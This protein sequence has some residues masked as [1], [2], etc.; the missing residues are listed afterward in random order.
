MNVLPDLVQRVSAN[1]ELHE[2]PDVL[3]FTAALLECSRELL[4]ALIAEKSMRVDVDVTF[5]SFIRNL[6]DRAG[7]LDARPV[8]TR[9]QA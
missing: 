5:R 6:H 4:V 9:G 7:E 2:L 1:L 3:R 8:V